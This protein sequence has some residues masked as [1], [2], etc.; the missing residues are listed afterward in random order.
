MNAKTTNSN[1]QSLYKVGGVAALIAGVIFRRNIAA[2]VSLFSNRASPT[3]IG[4]WFELLQSNRLL[5]LTYLN[6]FDLVNYLL[7]GLM[8][9]ALYVV[10][11]NIEKNLMTVAAAFGFA[12]IVIYFATNTAFSMLSLSEQYAIATTDLQRS[13]LLGAGQAVL[14]LNRFSGSGAYPGSGGYMSLMF[15]AAASVMISIVMMRSKI[16][17]PLTAYIGILAG[18]LD[19]VYGL[20]FVFV[21]GIPSD[22]LALIFI[23]VAGLFWMIWHIMVGWRLFQLGQ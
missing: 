15:I 6:I 9:L 17:N 10:L 14:S 18:V 23:P 20:A 22:V 19:L 4:D 1:G 7:V 16:F 3:T 21:A 2:E 11:V 12:G 5:A 8:F 13:I